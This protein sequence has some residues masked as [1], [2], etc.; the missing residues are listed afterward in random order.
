MRSS[1]GCM[2]R[3]FCHGGSG[4]GAARSPLRCRAV[5]IWR[6]TLTATISCA[7]VHACATRR[8]AGESASGSA[9]MS[10][11]A[12]PPVQRFLDAPES[13]SIHSRWKPEELAT[14]P[15]RRDDPSLELDFEAGI[16]SEATPFPSGSKGPVAIAEAAAAG[17]LGARFEPG[18]GGLAIAIAGKPD[19]SYLFEFQ[20]RRTDDPSRRADPEGGRGLGEAFVLEVPAPPADRAVLQERLAHAFEG[21]LWIFAAHEARA[22]RAPDQS[23]GKVRLVFKTGARTHGL[24]VVLQASAVARFV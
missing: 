9:T 7:C 2:A 24:I 4:R 21:R 19:T 15:E 13:L 1:A 11:A 20:A 10:S 8:D 3:R 17:V 22:P 12:I 16:P 18:G 6:V 5:R 14:R 23:F